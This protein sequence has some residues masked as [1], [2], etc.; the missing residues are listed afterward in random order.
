MELARLLRH[1]AERGTI[2]QFKEQVLRIGRCSFSLQWTDLNAS[3]TETVNITDT[4]IVDGMSLL[5]L[6]ADAGRCPGRSSSQNA[7]THT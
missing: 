7:S 4:R 5:G 3:G 1:G 2:R 6:R